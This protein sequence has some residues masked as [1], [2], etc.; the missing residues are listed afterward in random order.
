[1]QNIK[2][3]KEISNDFSEYDIVLLCYENEKNTVVKDVLKQYNEYSKIKI[4]V[5]IGPEGG[6]DISEVEYMQELRQVLL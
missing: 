6:I 3:V 4:A 5:I 2:N 1:M